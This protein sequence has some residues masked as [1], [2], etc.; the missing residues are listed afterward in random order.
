[1]VK[2][3]AAFNEIRGTGFDGKLYFA[4]YQL[5]KLHIDQDI[6]SA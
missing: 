3:I 2:E 5:F 6:V 1:M 4:G